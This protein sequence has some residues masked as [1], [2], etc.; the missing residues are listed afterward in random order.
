MFNQFFYRPLFN[1]LVFLYTH[2][3]FHDLGIAIVLLTVLVRIVLYP[4]FHKS[5]RNQ[6]I[7]QMIQPKV[8]KIQ[9]A[10]KDNKEKQAAAL[11]EVY[12]E[13]KVN[14]FSSFLLLFVQIPVLIALYRVFLS[15]LGANS[16]DALYS[17]IA[18]PAAFNF[19][20]L[21]LI[22][23]HERS[24]LMVGLTALAQYLQARSALP[25]AQKGSESTSAEKMARQMVFMGPVLAFVIL[26]NLPAAISLYWLTGALFSLFQQA[27][28]NRS[29]KDFSSS[30]GISTNTTR[31]DAS[32]GL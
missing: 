23:L 8:K 10:H 30:N 3:S 28:V 1:A 7:M 21:G 26:A 5:V 2:V 4:F 11:L 9:E 31:N 29:L 17:F 27:M 6:R 19:N 12:R 20:F 14:P 15:G 32:Q 18:K 25:P 24:M 13:H 22:N 16:F